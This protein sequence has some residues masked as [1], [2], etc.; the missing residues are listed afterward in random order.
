RHRLTAPASASSYLPPSRTT[1]WLIL[2]RSRLAAGQ[3][4]TVECRERAQSAAA[5][6]TALLLGGECQCLPAVTRRRAETCRPAAAAA[7]RTLKCHCRS[8][9]ASSLKPAPSTWTTLFLKSTSW[10]QDL[11][12][13]S[14]ES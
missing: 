1:K 12:S 5:S 4:T 14:T 2:T 8:G 7:S 6:M 11:H 13:S 10:I 3:P 9:H